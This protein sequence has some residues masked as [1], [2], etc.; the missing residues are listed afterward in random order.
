MSSF[1]SYGGTQDILRQI[2]GQQYQPIQGPRVDNPMARFFTDAMNRAN[3]AN[4]QRYQQAI[5]LVAGTG[6]G[7]KNRIRRST[8][9]GKS[10]DQQSLI[11]RGLFSTTITDSLSRQRDR[12]MQEQFTQVDDSIA[13]RIA[14]IIQSRTDRGPDLGLFAQ[15]L[16]QQAQAE[17]SGRRPKG[18]TNAVIPALPG[19]Q[20][21][22]GAGGGAGGGFTG[23]TGGGGSNV[24]GV[25]SF[26]NRAGGYTPTRVS[27]EAPP[28]GYI[29]R[30]GCRLPDGSIWRAPS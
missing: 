28:C 11:D 9:I 18:R 13:D 6:E 14:S 7:A 4:Q 27:R 10:R 25:R 15:L 29:K 3:Q 12:D 17:E 20:M 24:E 19:P 16:Q 2:M 26:A 23:S 22:G 1:S 5:G 21:G 8:R 30:N